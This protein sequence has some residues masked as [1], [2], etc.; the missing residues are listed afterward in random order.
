MFKKNKRKWILIGLFLIIVIVFLSPM[1]PKKSYIEDLIKMELPNTS[2][3]IEYKFGVNGYGLDPFY[4]KVEIDQETF[5][6]WSEKIT[7]DYEYTQGMMESIMKS[8]NY[9]SLNMDEVED[10]RINELMTD[11]YY[12]FI[13]GSTRYVYFI[14]TKEADGH[15][16]LYVLY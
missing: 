9:E 15:Y 4:T 13:A 16:Y 11:R 8:T 3:I 12:F 2:K 6:L 14:I 10:I 5:E 1:I 7:Y